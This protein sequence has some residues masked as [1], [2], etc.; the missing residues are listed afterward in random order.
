MRDTHA[1]GGSPRPSKDNGPIQ[2]KELSSQYG[3]FRHLR[4]GK[5]FYT[6]KK[7]V[8]TGLCSRQTLWHLLKSGE[9]GYLKIDTRMLIPRSE[10]VSFVQSHYHK[11]GG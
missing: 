1:Q 3:E 6:I 5:H 4:G 10:L 9:I 8:S 11:D 7:V 2:G